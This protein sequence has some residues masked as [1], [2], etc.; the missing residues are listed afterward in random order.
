MPIFGFIHKL[1]PAWRPRKSIPGADNMPFKQLTL[2]DGPI[3]REFEKSH[4]LVG[5]DANFT[6]MVI[7]LS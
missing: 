5:S 1:L 7:W 2:D 4:P 3:F 6:N